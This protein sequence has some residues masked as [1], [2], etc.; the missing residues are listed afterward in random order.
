MRHKFYRH[1]LHLGE[2]GLDVFV[3]DDQDNEFLVKTNNVAKLYH[4]KVHDGGAMWS[5][6]YL[7]SLTPHRNITKVCMKHISRQYLSL[8]S[9]IV[10][11]YSGS[12]IFL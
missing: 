12:Y 2:T 9:L 6:N 3:A 5:K 8:L 1:V 10:L 7:L 11:L 4:K